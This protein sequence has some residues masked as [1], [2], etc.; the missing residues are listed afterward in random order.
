M[1]GGRSGSGGGSS[2]SVDDGMV[3]VVEGNSNLLVN[4][5]R[6]KVF[7]LDDKCERLEREKA[8]LADLL[9][10]KR[11]DAELTRERYS[12]RIRNLEDE[13]QMLKTEKMRL[14]DRLKLPEKERQETV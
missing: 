7:A 10:T 3:T 14:V 13:S 8:A 4:N 2:G 12:E 5:L 1:D 9:A 6:E 11:R